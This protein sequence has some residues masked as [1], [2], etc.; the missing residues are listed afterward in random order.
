LFLAGAI[1][2]RGAGCIVNDLFDRKMDAEVARTSTRPLAAGTVTPAQAGIL[3]GVLVFLSLLIV[4]AMN[5]LTLLLAFLSL[6]LI[7][8]YPLMKRITWWPQAFLGITFNFG[9]LMGTAAALDALTPASFVLYAACFFWTLGYDTIY[10]AQ[11]VIDDEKTGIKSTTRLF[12]AAA[13]KWVGLFYGLCW[14]LLIIA[15]MLEGLGLGFYIGMALAM[16]EFIGQIRGWRVGDPANSLVM[17]K[18]N[19]VVAL[20]ILFAIV[21]GHY[22]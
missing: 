10:A 13:P 19:V 17:F 5:G 7:A 18:S 4:L 11:D 21:A 9:A 8:A 6:P 15:G 2:M 14:L 20:V 12:G 3:A 16:R 1:L 22:F